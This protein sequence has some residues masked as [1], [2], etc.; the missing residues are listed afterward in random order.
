MNDAMAK[1]R[2]FSFAALTLCLIF[3]AGCATIHGIMPE[4]PIS[5]AHDQPQEIPSAKIPTSI[6]S[7]P[8]AS[9]AQNQILD[10]VPNSSASRTMHYPVPEF[11][12]FNPLNPAMHEYYLTEQAGWPFV[13]GYHGLARMLPGATVFVGLRGEASG[14]HKSAASP[15]FLKMLAEN[16]HMGM[17]TVDEYRYEDKTAKGSRPLMPICHRSW[18]PGGYL[19]TEI[20]AFRDGGATL[21]LEKILPNRN[22]VVIVSYS[23]STSPRSELIARTLR[24]PENINYRYFGNPQKFLTEYIL[25]TDFSDHVYPNIRGFIDIEGNFEYTKNFWDLMAYLKLEV[26]RDQSKFFYSAVRIEKTDAYPVQTTMIRLLGLEGQESDEGVIR[27]Q[28]GKGNIIIDIITNPY[29]PYYAGVGGDIRRLT[30]MKVSTSRNIRRGR[31]THLTM[32]DWVA[33]RFFATTAFLQNGMTKT[34]Q[35]ASAAK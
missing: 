12:L 19:G 14:F 4:E 10:C 20:P 7:L 9:L 26:E 6:A 30:K 35:S 28:N 18:L 22:P 33:Q 34:Y 5:S 27:F 15:A 3:N 23:N 16:P 8:I 2:L 13:V 24:K 21:M 25:K 17:I 11:D 1:S 29:E 31:V 32:G